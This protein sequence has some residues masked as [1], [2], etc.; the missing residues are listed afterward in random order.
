MSTTI[1]AQ[2]ALQIREKPMEVY[3]TLQTGSSAK[4]SNYAPQG[5]YK[6]YDSTLG[7][8]AY[9]MRDIADLAGEG[10]P[11]DGSH[12]LYDPNEGADATNG[13]LGLRGNAGANVSV[14][15]T[16]S[17][18]LTAVTVSTRGVGTI[19]VSGGASYPSAGLNVIPINAT[20]ATLTFTPAAANGRAEVDY[21][22]P[23]IILSATNDTLTRCTLALRGNLD[24]I[25][26]SWEESEIE[27]EMYY[28][29]DIS[30]S[31]A[32]VQNEWPI[33]YRA[34]YD[35]DLSPE[36]KFY[37]SEPVEMKDNI[38]TIKGVD[39]SHR[40]DDKTMP[41][42][43]LD[44][45]T[46]NAHE[47]IYQKFVNAIKSA[48]ITVQ[49]QQA[50]SGTTGGTWQHAILPEMTVR[51]FVAGTM[52]LTANHIRDNVSYAIQFVD[53]GIP[54][55]EH[56]D[57]TNFGQIWTINKSDCGEWQET[58][59]RS[60][61][62]IVETDDERN[63][64]E[65]FASPRNADMIVVYGYGSSFGNTRVKASEYKKQI[66]GTFIDISLDGYFNALTVKGV[67]TISLTP[68][69]F[70][71][72]QKADTVITKTETI[73]GEK[74]YTI[75]GNSLIAGTYETIS[76][77]VK[78]FSNPDGLPGQTIEME[79]FVYGAILDANGATV[80]NYPSL[81][82]R[83][84]H[85]ISFTWK[86]DPRMQPLDY[87]RLYDDTKPTITPSIWY[88]ITSIE[89][90]HEG[91]GTTAN[92]EA[93]EWIRPTSVPDY[94]VLGDDSGRHIVTDDNKDI[95]VITEGE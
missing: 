66:K 24:V 19:S 20:T 39:A 35:G 88:R 93:R 40:L 43:W 59:E 68:T 70:V 64:N 46:N 73:L 17:A 75:T 29:Y 85:T 57:G 41:E 49:R 45:Q 92:I 16:A 78:S 30:S 44:I 56:G 77:G 83:S 94:Y 6:S 28:P 3:I 50:W 91:G 74:W 81:F 32:Y 23:G 12:R 27:F 54:T 79:P 7:N 51:D 34:G 42:Q 33:T 37:L 67:N 9:S 60:I 4:I 95:L 26:H 52:N 65:H 47:A 90:N 69:H 53:A 86:G 25:D 1:N 55:V 62:K 72:T 48:G 36:R 76:G 61:A 31:F 2:N 71:G 87:I 15:I 80:F 11:L 58:R 10:F 21:I 5:T 14:E 18:T 82:N 13:K 89:L 63:F 84:T 38:I 8:T 22:V